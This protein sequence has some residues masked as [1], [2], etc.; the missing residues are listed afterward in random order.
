M[1]FN[2]KN[3]VYLSQSNGAGPGLPVRGGRL[4]NERPMP[5]MGIV[6]A[7][8]ARREMKQE[9]KIQMQSEAYVRGEQMS[10]LNEMMMM[11]KNGCSDCMGK[12]GCSSCGY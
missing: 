4:I 6:Q 12:G 10:E 11:G 1:K 8:N 9:R 7:A 3:S 5:E 2:I